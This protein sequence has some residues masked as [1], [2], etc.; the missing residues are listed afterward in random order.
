VV[1]LDNATGEILALVSSASWTDPRGGQLNGATLPRSPGS[2]LKPFTYILAMEKNH[3][4]PCSILADIPSP[5]RTEQG[6]DLPQNYDR[7]YRG[8]VTLR[9]ALACSLNIPAMRELNHLGGAAP[10]HH[11]LGTLGI[12]T[13]GDAPGSYG[14]G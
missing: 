8:P 2:T 4:I 5:F 6:L 10:L 7:Q 1:V 9:T 3:R 12:T 11:F 14:L 13:L